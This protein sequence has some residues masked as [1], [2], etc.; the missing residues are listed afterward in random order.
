MSDRFATTQWSQVLA[1]RDRGG[2]EARNALAALFEVYWY[3]LYA[4]IRRQGYGPEDAQDLTQGYF[5]YLIDKQVLSAV[6]PDAGRFRSF[7]LV[8]LKHYL[9]HERDRA[10]ALKR[11]GGTQT[12]SLDAASAEQRYHLEP[13]D[14][15]TPEQVF[16]RRWALTVVERSLERLRQETAEG[17]RPA[18]FDK[19]KGCLT[20]EEPHTPYKEVARELGMSEVAMRGTV[21]RMR[22]RLGRFLRSEI[23]ETVADPGQVDDEVRHL[24]TAIGPWEPQRS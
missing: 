7:L 19:V 5:S 9:S 8:T 22:Q 3:P 1:A 2:T 11:G 21:H 17:D 12:V 14:N 18:L 24:L 6:D 23:A 16:E 20:G 15:L 13:E 4:F 10:A